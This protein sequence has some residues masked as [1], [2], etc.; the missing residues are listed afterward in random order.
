MSVFGDLTEEELEAEIAT[1]RMRIRGQVSDAPVK[2][3]AGEGRRVEYMNMSPSDLRRL[4]REALEALA[5]IQGNTG[6]R[7]IGVRFP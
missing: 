4:L 7:A 3:V 2:S 6:G 1:I 5:V